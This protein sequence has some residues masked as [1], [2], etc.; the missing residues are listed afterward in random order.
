MRSSRKAGPFRPGRL[1]AQ[2]KALAATGLLGFALAVFCG[3][4]T[5]IFG[6]EMGDGGNISK[7]VSFNAAVGIFLLSTAAIAPYSA[8]GR[9]GRAFFRWGYVA[10]AF[11]AYF[12]ETV[13]NFRGVNPRFVENGSAF[14]NAVAILFGVVALL[15]V[16][17]YLPFAG[18]FFTRRSYKANPALATGIR[19]AMV[20]VFL[21]FAAGIWISMNQGRY[22]GLSGNIIWLHG[23]G[24]HALQAM[25]FAAWLVSFGT[26]T[27]G[28]KLSLHVIGAG[29]IGGLV[30]IGLQ[31]LRGHT[32]LEWS[33]WPLL[34][35]A[36]FMIAAVP[37]LMLLREAMKKA[38]DTT[39]I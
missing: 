32:M 19:Y 39:A 24:F 37:V 2:E 18:S 20:A 8:M 13:Q 38:P 21:S 26:G 34:A 5:L 11:Y 22:V 12:A 3:V 9:G 29:Y 4:W 25:P 30:M 15:L 36:C 17:L 28:K 6:G 14:D 33:A 31:T 7:A 35:L 23:L 10:L 27:G 16:L 1:F